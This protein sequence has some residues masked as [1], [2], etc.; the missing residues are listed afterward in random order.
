MIFSSSI[1]LYAFLPIFLATYYAS[2]RRARSLVI[3]LFSY[4]FYGWW[5]PDFVLLMLISTVVDYSCGRAIVSARQAN[6]DGEGVGKPFLWISLGVNLGL[7]GYFKYAN[8]GIDTV[9]ALLVANGQAPME[10]TRVVLPVGISFYT[11]QTLSYTVDLYRGH[12]EPVKNFTDFMCYVA[13]FPQLIAGP[14]VRYHTVAEQLHGRTHSAEKFF[15]GVV[16]FQIGLIKKVLLA[17]VVAD[18]ANSA[19]GHGPAGFVDAWIG[20]VAYAFQIY[21]DFSGYSDMA[22]GLG[23]MIGF[24]LP[25]NFDRPYASES[26]TDFW[27]RW[28]ISLSSFLRDYLYIP[29]G[30]NRKGPRRTYVNL[31]ATML[32]GGLWHGAAWTFVAWGAYQGA[33][34]AFERWCG[35]RPLYHR[36]PRPGRIAITF[37]I[38][39]GGWVFFRAPDIG[40]AFDYL[41]TMAGFGGDFDDATPLFV[42][43]THYLGLGIGAFVLWCMPTTQERLLNLRTGYVLLLQ[44]LFILALLHLH[45]QD[46]VPFLYYQF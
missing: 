30:G 3:A 10:W 11:F 25:I 39:L 9:N 34:L 7:L 45:Y 24:H 37:V 29:L 23:L 12:A 21:F 4:L 46:H 1:F 36:F 2:P 16:A 20:I 14:I 35:K 43:P 19:F 31:M 27:R 6:P 5:R 17:D 15:Y 33:F 42:R 22:I 44:A 40:F 32:L 26:I 28:H 13:M 41:S 38:V 8:F 18:L